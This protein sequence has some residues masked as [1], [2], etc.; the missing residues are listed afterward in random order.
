MPVKVETSHL[1]PNQGN[2]PEAYERLFYDII[3]GDATLFAWWNEV[4]AS[5]KFADQIIAF[6]EISKQRFPNYTSGSSGPVKAIELLAKD[7]VNGGLDN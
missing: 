6:R 7:G 1:S 5:W 4:E 3:R 2:T